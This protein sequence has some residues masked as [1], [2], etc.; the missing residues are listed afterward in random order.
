[1]HVHTIGVKPLVKINMIYYVYTLYLR[2]KG[3]NNVH[4][5]GESKQIRQVPV[6]CGLASS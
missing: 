5:Y 6:Y 4:I 2:N 3:K 1:M